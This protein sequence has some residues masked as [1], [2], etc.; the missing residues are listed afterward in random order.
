[1]SESEAT[2]LH[3]TAIHAGPEK[4][5]ATKPPAAIE[6]VPAASPAVEQEAATPVA[7]EPA[8]SF[9]DI[10]TQFEKSHSQRPEEG[11]NQIEATV[12]ALTADAALFDIGFKTEGTLPVAALAGK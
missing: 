10:L 12:V 6:A 4:E 11:G 5:E 2:D 7:P 9:S 3:A 8:E 1:M